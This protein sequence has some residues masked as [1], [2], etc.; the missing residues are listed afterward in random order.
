M[1]LPHRWA[2]ACLLVPQHHPNLRPP[3][4]PVLASLP[5]ALSLPHVQTRICIPLFMPHSQV[6][7]MTKHLQELKP[8]L[9]QTAEDTEQL[10]NKIEVQSLEAEK[11][12]SM[13]AVEEASCN[14]KAA[15]AKVIKDECEQQLQEVMP[16]LDAATKA[17]SQISRKE[18]SE[19]RSMQA[20]SDKIKK[21]L[22]GVVAVGSYDMQIADAVARQHHRDIPPS[23]TQA[24]ARAR[25]HAFFGLLIPCFLQSFLCSVSATGPLA[26]AP[27]V[28]TITE[29]TPPAKRTPPATN[30][31]R[32]MRT[33]DP[34]RAQGVDGRYNAWKSGAPGPHAHG[35]AARQ[36]VDVLRTEV[37]GQQKPSNDPRNNQ[38]SPNTPTTGRR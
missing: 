21:V 16:A 28:S 7:T 32:V 22:C 6:G 15:S 35:N 33:R 18:L 31:E 30:K 24:H 38:H 4:S 9:A 2:V 1:G 11:T 20:P 5:H 8:T 19:I 37:W 34:W 25:A 36:A 10:I 14:R 17:V 13:V 3:T 23:N 29:R 26:H 27:P 12:R